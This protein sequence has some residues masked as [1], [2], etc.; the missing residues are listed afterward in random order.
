[1]R[2]MSFALTTEQVRNQTKTVTRR[3]GWKTLKPGTLIQPV[4][5]GM[6]LGKGGKVEKIGGPI[7]VVSVRLESLDS[8]RAADVIAGYGAPEVVREGFQLMTA[9]EFV[10][11][12]CRHN[13]CGPSTAVTR[14]EFKYVSSDPT[15]TQEGTR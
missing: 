7:R 6:G 13:K 10:A 4:V 15:R 12:F 9:Q 3:L 2:N 14:I 8:I 11:M 1:M 5:K